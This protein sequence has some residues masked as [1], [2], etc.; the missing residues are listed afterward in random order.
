LI[1]AASILSNCTRVPDREVVVQTE[2]I[3]PNIRIVPRPRPVDLGDISF[4]VVTAENLDEV[5]ADL[6]NSSGEYVFYAITVRDYEKIAL[7]IQE[8]RRF[9]LQQNEIIL[10]YEEAVSAPSEQ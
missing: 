1:L 5:L 6:S 3:T 9:I 2:Y 10:Y 4:K 7:N 8:L